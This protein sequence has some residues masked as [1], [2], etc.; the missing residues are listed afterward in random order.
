MEGDEWINVKRKVKK[1]NRKGGSEW[2]IHVIR[3]REREILIRGEFRDRGRKEW[4]GGWGGGGGR[5][6]P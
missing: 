2:W 3:E 6:P 1:E 4:H 5:S